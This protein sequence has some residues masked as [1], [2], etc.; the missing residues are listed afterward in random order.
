[1]TRVSSIKDIGQVYNEMLKANAP[2]V[3]QKKIEVV[4]E[5]VVK[6][7][8]TFPKA[9]DKKIDVKKL[10][11]K[12][13]DKKAFVHKK[14]G[15]EG[16][17]GVSTDIVDPKTAKKDNFYTP[18]KFSTALEKTGTEGINNH[19]KSIFD[20]LYEDVMKDDALDLGIQAGPEGES[21]DKAELDLSGGSEHTVTVKLDKDI[22]QK[23]HDALV[24]VLGGEEDKGDTE[25]LD[26]EGEVDDESEEI[27]AATENEEK[28]DH[29]KKDHEKDHEKEE[30]EE[31]AAEATHLEQLPDSKGQSLQKKGG[32]PTVGSKTG[33][34]KSHKASGN[35]SAEV[36]AKGSPVADSKGLSL[37]G[38]NNKVNA[39]GYKA[40][41][42]FK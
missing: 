4:E 9:T 18:Q 5:K 36:D 24:E 23:L 26:G 3:E 28:K 1:M 30:Q 2:V 14:S 38:K 7:L 42:F 34:V 31:V 10:T 17:E 29:E 22:A 8:P 19:M 16:V 35:V 41:D 11:S 15:P 32:V 25:D 21:G 13:S 40:G 6:H 33:H 20:K 12:G 37:T 27:P 39:P